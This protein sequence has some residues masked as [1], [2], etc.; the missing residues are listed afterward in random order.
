MTN[1][2]DDLVKWLDD[3]SKVVGKEAGDLTQKGSLK[4]EI[5]DLRRK[6]RDGYTELG[7]HIYD[8]VYI[9]KKENWKNLKTIKSAAQRIKTI[10]RNISKKTAEYTK[11]G[12]EKKLPK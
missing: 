7:K 6:L 1:I 11:I 8:A 9:K 12:K 5:F 3:A 4:M 10:Q 2:W